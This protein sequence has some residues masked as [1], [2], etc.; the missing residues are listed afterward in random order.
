[1]GKMY[2]RFLNHKGTKDAKEHEGMFLAGKAGRN[3]L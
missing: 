2:K 3:A 1:M